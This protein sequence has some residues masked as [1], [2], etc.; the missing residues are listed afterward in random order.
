MKPELKHAIET[1]RDECK[2]HGDNREGSALDDPIFLKDV[3]ALDT[4]IDFIKRNYSIR[5]VVQCKDCKDSRELNRKDP[6]EN[7]FIEG[8]LWCTN[9]RGGVLPEQFCDEG[10]RKREENEEVTS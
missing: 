7:R 1:I 3:E 8:C 10:E 4:V 6:Y 9:G 2:K 5:E